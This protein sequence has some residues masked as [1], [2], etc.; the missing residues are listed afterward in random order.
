MI[1]HF[2]EM[3]GL[4]SFRWLPGHGTRPGARWLAGM[5]GFTGF[6]DLVQHQPKP[7]ARDSIYARFAVVRR[8]P[9]WAGRWR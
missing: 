2:R 5:G 4:N 8:A 3:A 6:N 7:T 1:V 9:P